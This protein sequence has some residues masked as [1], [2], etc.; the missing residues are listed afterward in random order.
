[1]CCLLQQTGQCGQWVE[2][3]RNRTF[4]N[5]VLLYFKDS[6]K[7]SEHFSLLI[8]RSEPSEL[9]LSIVDSDILSIRLLS[10]L[11]YCMQFMVRAEPMIQVSV[12]TFG[13]SFNVC[14]LQIDTKLYFT[15]HEACLTSLL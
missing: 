5:A 1:M 2:E 9:F 10:V 3:E 14:F 13:T 12:F 7:K 6:F 15:A 8:E 11:D 4:I